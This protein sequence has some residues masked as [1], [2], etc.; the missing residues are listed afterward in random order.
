LVAVRFHGGG[1]ERHRSILQILG[2]NRVHDQLPPTRG[3]TLDAIVVISDEGGYIVTR[4][5]GPIVD[6]GPGDV[7][8][9]GALEL[10]EIRTRTTYDSMLDVPQPM[11]WQVRRRSFRSRG[12]FPP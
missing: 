4:K 8:H 10:R 11:P 3:K 5:R 1:A 9:E 2:P 12:P 6:L 7:F